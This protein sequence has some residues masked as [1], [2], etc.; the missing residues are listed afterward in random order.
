GQAIG[1]RWPGDERRW[2][3]GPRPPPPISSLC[4]RGAVPALVVLRRRTIVTAGL[5]EL[6]FRF[7]QHLLTQQSRVVVPTRVDFISV[8]FAAFGRCMQYEDQ[9]CLVVLVDD[10]GV[11][12]SQEGIGEQAL[13][14]RTLHHFFSA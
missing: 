14:A 9:A 4:P 6:R 13:V 8:G 7:R 12:K 2:P 5:R 10:Q 11:E 3:A 1:R